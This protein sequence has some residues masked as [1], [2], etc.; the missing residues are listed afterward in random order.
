MDARFLMYGL[1]G[2]QKLTEHIAFPVELDVAQALS[3]SAVAEVRLILVQLLSLLRPLVIV[4]LRGY[5]YVQGQPSKY[6]LH[7]VL[8]HHGHTA[9]SGHY[10]AFTQAPNGLWH[11]MDDDTVSI[12]GWPVV[13]KQQA[14]MLFYTRVPGQAAPRPSPSLRGLEANGSAA[15]PAAI[16]SPVA[17][18]KGVKPVA[19]GMPE[20]ALDSLADHVWNPKP[21]PNANGAFSFG[22]TAPL[23]L[24]DNPA[25]TL[26]AAMRASTAA[27]GS[28][29]LLRAPTSSATSNNGD[30]HHA[31]ASTGSASSPDASGS[32]SP[33]LSTHSATAKGKTAIAGLQVVS[34]RLHDTG[35]V[36]NRPRTLAPAEEATAKRMAR[37]LKQLRQWR[38]VSA[39]GSGPREAW[40]WDA[41]A[42][43]VAYCQQHGLSPPEVQLL[44]PQQIAAF[45]PPA[46]VLEESSDDASTEE[47]S[48]SDGVEGVEGGSDKAD[49]T[50][51]EEGEANDSESGDDDDYDEAYN[52]LLRGAPMTNGNGSDE[53]EDDEDDSDYTASASDQERAPGTA[54]G[55]AAASAT[56]DDFSEDSRFPVGGDGRA[57]TAAGNAVFAHSKAGSNLPST[58]AASSKPDRP[59]NGFNPSFT[60]DRVLVT[61]QRPIAAASF[62]PKA[63]A[64]SAD[65]AA[66][67]S[68]A[69]G[70]I[71]DSFDNPQAATSA[72]SVGPAAT[73]AAGAKRTRDALDAYL[74]SRGNERAEWDA[75]LDIGRTKKV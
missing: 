4:C 61:D 47:A 45:T 37:R 8:V 38:Q 42:A 21:V 27:V 41:H 10:Y 19:N 5:V 40:A 49:A 17:T 15:K 28:G 72:S 60:R 50:S 12:S 6:S 74:D 20:F 2:N 57:G 55:T 73:E 48:A 69:D 43:R 58:T 33:A 46:P 64:A 35:S 53:G 44:T 59:L 14:Y 7:G 25:A 16:S 31:T 39:G 65:A 70:G 3:D 32:I 62:D 11:C 63:L 29:G 1:G 67:F 54:A 18:A 36:P 34:P 13:S 51:E 56:G 9:N 26:K 24:S 66:S 68:W 23:P 52:R 75:R 30:A 71:W 22:P